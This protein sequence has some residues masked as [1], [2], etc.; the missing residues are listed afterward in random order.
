MGIRGSPLIRCRTSATTPAPAGVVLPLALPAA[1]SG[2]ATVRGEIVPIPVE[3]ITLLMEEAP[4]GAVLAQP[5]P[6]PL[7]VGRPEDLE[8]ARFWFRERTS[9]VSP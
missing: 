1:A 3:L 2:T 5:I 6:T 7:H 8:E 4:H 9:G